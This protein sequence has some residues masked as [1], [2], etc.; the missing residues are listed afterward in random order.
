MTEKRK[1]RRVNRRLSVRYGEQEPSHAAFTTDVSSGGCFITAAR[2]PPL[3][4]RLHVQLLL[5]TGRSLYFEGEVRR[6]KQVPAGLTAAAKGGFSVRF[7]PPAEAMTE[8]LGTAPSALV[9]RFASAQALAQAW[10][11]EL[12]VGG[13]FVPTADRLARDAV[14]EVQLNLA[15]LERTFSFEGRV[16]HVSPGDARSLPGVGVAFHEPERLGQVLRPFLS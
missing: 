10:T 1:H 16:V 15:W 8:V 14:V 12:R 5:G 7:L 2:L 6:H 11:R 13:A 9:L 3:H 4:T